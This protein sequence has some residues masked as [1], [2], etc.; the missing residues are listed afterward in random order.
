MISCLSA[1]LVAGWVK[2]GGPAAAAR[3]GDGRYVVRRVGE[4]HG[5]FGIAGGIGRMREPVEDGIT[6]V[7][8]GGRALGNSAYANSASVSDD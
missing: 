7:G 3:E 2:R 6:T 5:V 1:S 8:R 4:S